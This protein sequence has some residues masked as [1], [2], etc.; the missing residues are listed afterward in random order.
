MSYL[1]YGNLLDASLQHGL[2]NRVELSGRAGVV[3]QLA[4][5]SDNQRGTALDHNLALA[6]ALRQ[7]GDQQT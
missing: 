1:F 3:H 4:H 7:D 5:V 2:E 6:H